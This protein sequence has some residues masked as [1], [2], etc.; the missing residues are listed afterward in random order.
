MSCDSSKIV[1][2]DTGPIWH[3]TVPEIDSNGLDTGNDATLTNY[4]CS[5]KVDTHTITV[6]S[7]NV[8]GDAFLAQIGS[9]VTAQL[10]AGGYNVGIEV[11]DDTVSPPYV[12]EIHKRIQ[13]TAE[14]V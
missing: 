12:S 7:K 10:D 4:T 8:A 14:R 6:T 3:V 9:D 11:R 1:I 13:I 2:G 5:I